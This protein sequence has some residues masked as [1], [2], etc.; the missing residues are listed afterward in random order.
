MC[1]RSNSSQQKNVVCM[2]QS[3]DSVGQSG[4]EFERVKCGR[5]CNLLR[6]LVHVGRDHLHGHGEGAGLVALERAVAMEECLRP[7]KGISMQS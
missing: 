4:E 7:G 1:I 3:C 6:R 2:W 5:D